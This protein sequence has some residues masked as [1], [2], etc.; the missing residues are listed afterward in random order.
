MWSLTAASRPRDDPADAR[1]RFKAARKAAKTAR[2]RGEPTALDKNPGERWLEDEDWPFALVWRLSMR[3]GRH[4]AWGD[5]LAPSGPQDEGDKPGRSPAGAAQVAGPGELQAPPVGR[6]REAAATV[7]S[8]A[9]SPAVGELACA[10]SDGRVY[11]WALSAAQGELAFR[12]HLLGHTNEVT[13]VG[14]PAARPP[15]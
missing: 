14:W 4:D 2:A 8:V 11:V 3:Q 6:I 7:T 10:C 13:E 12:G 1:E 15:S 5:G 9:F